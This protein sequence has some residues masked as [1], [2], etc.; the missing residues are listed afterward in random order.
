MGTARLSADA[1]EL[2]VL[3]VPP[4]WFF[5]RA[6]WPSDWVCRAGSEDLVQIRALPPTSFI[7]LER[8][9]VILSYSFLKWGMGMIMWERQGKR[10]R[11]T[12]R[13][14]LDELKNLEWKMLNN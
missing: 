5:L 9:P 11:E 2:R 12:G 4:L 7:N 1:T 6:A 8:Y 3:P 14:R 13:G 10:G